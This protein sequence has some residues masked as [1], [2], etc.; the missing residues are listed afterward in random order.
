MRLDHLLSREYEKEAQADHGSEQRGRNCESL[1]KDVLY[2]FEGAEAYF[3][4]GKRTKAGSPWGCSSAG[5]AP[6]LQAGG[7]RFEPVHLHHFIYFRGSRG[8]ERKIEGDRD[9]RESELAGG[10]KSMRAHSSAG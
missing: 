5:R 4:K 1:W 3:Q 7:H 2:S 10:Q 8:K 6:A 9:L